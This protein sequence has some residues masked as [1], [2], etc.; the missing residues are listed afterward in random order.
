V[1]LSACHS[2]S[3]TNGDEIRTRVQRCWEK[4]LLDGDAANGSATVAL[5][6]LTMVCRTFGVEAGG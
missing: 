1:A 4:T 3:N 2:S 6:V 5:G